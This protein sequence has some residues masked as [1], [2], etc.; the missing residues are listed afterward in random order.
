MKIR[1][2]VNEKN[3]SENEKQDKNDYDNNNENKYL[4]RKQ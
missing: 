3:D 4:Y 2:N 1:K